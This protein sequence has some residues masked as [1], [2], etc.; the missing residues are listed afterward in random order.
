[1]R[2]LPQSIRLDKCYRTKTDLVRLIT[3]IE[4]DEITYAPRGRTAFDNW[5]E[6][7]PRRTVAKKRFL[8]EAIEEIPYYWQPQEEPPHAGRL[9]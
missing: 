2:I 8:S 5:H 3:R 1:M 7:A 9:G 6:T 4:G